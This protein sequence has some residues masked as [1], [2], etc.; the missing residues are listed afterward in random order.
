M[1]IMDFY[2]PQ[3][4]NIALFVDGGVWHADPRL[5]EQDDTLFIKFRAL[6]KEWKNITAKGFWK[7]DRTHNDYLTPQKENSGIK[8]HY[9]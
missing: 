3:K 4:K 2:L 7:K 5:Y 9:K 1:G 8:T 6:K